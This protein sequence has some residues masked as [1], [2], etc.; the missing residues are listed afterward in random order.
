[1]LDDVTIWDKAL[2]QDDIQN[3]IKGGPDVAV[4]PVGKLTTTW[5]ALK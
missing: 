1:M 3:L 4:Q 2:D 5:G